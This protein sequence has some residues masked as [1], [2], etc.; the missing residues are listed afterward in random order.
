MKKS[1]EEQFSMFYLNCKIKKCFYD[2]RRVCPMT[3]SENPPGKSGFAACL[4]DDQNK[5]K[6]QTFIDTTIA[7]SVAHA[8]F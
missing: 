2:M 4:P 6:Y 3:L 8:H 5:I 7:L 1:L